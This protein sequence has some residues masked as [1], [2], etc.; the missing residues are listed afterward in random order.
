MKIVSL[1]NAEKA[2]KVY[3]HC[4]R[5]IYFRNNNDG[6]NTVCEIHLSDGSIVLVKEVA[7][8]LASLLDECK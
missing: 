8:G 4:E 6:P 3:I 1:N 2:G 7:T 5:I